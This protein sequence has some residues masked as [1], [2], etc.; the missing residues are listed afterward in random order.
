ML[1]Q[2]QG[3]LKNYPSISEEEYDFIKRNIPIKTYSKNEVFFKEG[4]IAQTIYFVLSGCVRLFYNADGNDKT[5]YFYTE[6]MFICANESYLHHTPANEN[7]QALEE[8]TVLLFHKSIESTLNEK[9]KNYQEIERLAIVEELIRSNRIIESFI[10]KK[11]EERYLELIQS[12]MEL[13]QRVHQQY[14][15]TYLGISPESLSRIRKRLAQK[16]KNH[17]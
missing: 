13:F 2:F 15:A 3:L 12:N 5:A 1:D 9:L 8:T 7:F 11:P 17:S 14:I 10:T 16:T 4:M 6:G